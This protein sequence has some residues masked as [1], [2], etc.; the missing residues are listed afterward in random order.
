MAQKFVLILCGL[1]LGCGWL[2]LM[3][4]QPAYASIQHTNWQRPLRQ[5]NGPALTIRT[6]I[7]ATVASTVTV[8]VD[9][10]HNAS[11]IA[12]MTFSISFDPTCLAFD[13]T[14]TNGDFTPDAVRFTLPPQFRGSAAYDPSDVDGELDIVIAD[15]NPP[16]A[17]LP[18][19]DHLLTITFTAIC[20][21]ASG[22]TLVT[23][24]DF[25]SAPPPSFGNPAGADVNGTASG[26]TII[27][28]HPAA[29][30]VTPTATATA[31]ATP[32][33][34]A[35]ATPTATTMPTNLDDTTEPSRPPLRVFLPWVGR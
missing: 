4:S 14:D 24:V 2:W 11:G 17:T 34:T 32:T 27:I 9:F 8:P 28:A 10:R 25:S 20:A 1:L 3:H 21:P 5:T 18:D 35:T 7:T 29:A 23:A 13:A 22:Q 33:P 19:T 6:G 15:F 30:T 26:G 16:L 31:T 12:S